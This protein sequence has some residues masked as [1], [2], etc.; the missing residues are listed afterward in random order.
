MKIYS[1]YRNKLSKERN[2]FK[3]EIIVHWQRADIVEKRKSDSI[4]NVDKDSWTNL[5]L[6]RIKT[7]SE[8][9]S[10]FFYPENVE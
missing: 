9:L 8:K 5:V 6:I 4:K 1:A 3:N 2:T 10:G 7:L